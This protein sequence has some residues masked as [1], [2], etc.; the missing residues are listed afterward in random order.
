MVYHTEVL[1]SNNFSLFMNRIYLD[2]TFVLLFSI[3]FQLIL[4]GDNLGSDWWSQ[5]FNKEQEVEDE[6]LDFRVLENGFVS[7]KSFFVVSCNARA[8]ICT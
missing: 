6:D 5:M 8:Q 3:C 1:N 2:S 7:I 4:L